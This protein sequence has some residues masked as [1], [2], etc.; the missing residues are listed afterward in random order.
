[1]IS[2]DLYLAPRLPNA[3][4][5]TSVPDIIESLEKLA[6]INIDWLLPSHGKVY[7]DA[8]IRLN[9][10]ADWYKNERDKILLAADTLNTRDYRQIFK[11]LYKE[12][13]NLEKITLAE[14][15]RLALI[16]GVLDPVK[17]LPASALA[18]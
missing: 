7:N 5:E 11:Y 8:S 3:F 4:Y 1:M 14:N 9:K 12:Y 6:G 13:N 10:L 15:S 16:R 18:L 17:T 2:G